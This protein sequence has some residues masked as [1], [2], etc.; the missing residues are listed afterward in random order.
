MQICNIPAKTWA[1]IYPSARDG[2]S[3][4][5]FIGKA[6]ELVQRW[7][8]EPTIQEMPRN[9]EDC[10]LQCN[11]SINPP[12]IE[13]NGVRIRARRI[14]SRCPIKECGVIQA[15]N[16]L[17]GAGEEDKTIAALTIHAQ[18]WSNRAIHLLQI[19]QCF[20]RAG[21]H[22]QISKSNIQKSLKVLIYKV[23]GPKT[24]TFSSM[25]TSPTMLHTQLIQDG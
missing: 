23:S 11:C 8:Q 18:W 4:S 9:I 15:W 21:L 13:N 12:K 16:T 7:C 22:W 17:I 3:W 19:L 5:P 20:D 24:D 1:S 14:V 6:I 10:A 2:H 25:L